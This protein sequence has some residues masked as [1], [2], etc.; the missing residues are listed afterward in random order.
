MA[1]LVFSKLSLSETRRSLVHSLGERKKN[2]TM[3][4]INS[5]IFKTGFSKAFKLRSNELCD[6]V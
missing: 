6:L 2:E 3:A 1:N 4:E 5:K